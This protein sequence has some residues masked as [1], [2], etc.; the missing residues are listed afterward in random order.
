MAYRT[1]TCNRFR[2][3]GAFLYHTD[4]DNPGAS[5][6]VKTDGDEFQ[7]VPFQRGEIQGGQKAVE[8][9]IAD[10]LR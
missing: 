3:V 9:R 6:T 2:A 10:Y 8:K 1:Y 4:L 7:S 5:I